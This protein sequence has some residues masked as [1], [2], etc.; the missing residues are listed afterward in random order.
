MICIIFTFLS[1]FIIHRL[2]QFNLETI[3]LEYSFRL[4][5]LRDEIRES[6]MNGEIKTDNWL[7]TFFDSTL[8]RTITVLSRVSIW[9]MLAGMLFPI[10]DEEYLS[11]IKKLEEDLKK[12]ENKY[13][14]QIYQRYTE[15]FPEFIWAR[16]PGLRFIIKRVGEYFQLKSRIQILTIKWANA[17][18]LQ[19]E[20]PETSTLRE[21]LIY[22]Q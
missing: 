10:K 4:Y 15:I 7:F 14:A 18:K 9:T 1:L 22:I 11:A 21:C 13:Y 16:H 20:A 5:V 2:R 8:S 19:T 12:E 3:A 17:I 6:A